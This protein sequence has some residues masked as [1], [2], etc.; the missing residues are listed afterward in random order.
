MI[1]HSNVEAYAVVLPSL[2]LMTVI[3][4][5]VVVLAPSAKQRPLSALA[6][7]VEPVGVIITRYAA[8]VIAVNVIVF[9]PAT[10]VLLPAR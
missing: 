10:K 6:T 4:T 9:T 5:E 7:L 2:Q 1:I 8:L 3:G